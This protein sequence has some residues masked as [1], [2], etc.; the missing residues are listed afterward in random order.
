[1]QGMPAALTCTALWQL[2]S[3]QS[4]SLQ[5]GRAPAIRHGVKAKGDLLVH[6][7]CRGLQPHA[8]THPQPTKFAQLQLAD[9]LS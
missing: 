7:Q 6:H 9:Y 5:R 1:M 2:P 8:D 4:H 3:G